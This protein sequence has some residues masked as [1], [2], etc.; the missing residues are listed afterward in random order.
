M[1]EDSECVEGC[2]YG[3][4]YDAHGY[5]V[6]GC[7]ETYIINPYSGACMYEEYNT[8]VSRNYGLVLLMFIIIVAVCGLLYLGL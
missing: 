1:N 6:E 8:L 3:S 7:P 4:L 5:C 2:P